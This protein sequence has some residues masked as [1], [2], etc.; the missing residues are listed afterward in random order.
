[1]FAGIRDYKN[2]CTADEC[3]AN[4]LQLIMNVTINNIIACRPLVA[5][6]NEWFKLYVQLPPMFGMTFDDI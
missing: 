5:S 6:Q 4:S 1:M 3:E 2:K